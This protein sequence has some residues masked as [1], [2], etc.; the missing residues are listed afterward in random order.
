VAYCEWN[1][2][3]IYCS[4]HKKRTAIS[5]CLPSY[6]QH[7]TSA[8]TNIINPST[9]SGRGTCSSSGSGSRC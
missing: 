2:I 6:T 5:K 9:Q 4:Y 7:R 3:N 1:R 8:V